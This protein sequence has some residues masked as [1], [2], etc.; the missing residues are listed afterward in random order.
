MLGFGGAWV[1]RNVM[2]VELANIG[3]SAPSRVRYAL[4]R[5]H[6]VGPTDASAT[7]LVIA[8]ASDAPDHPHGLE[9]LHGVHCRG[10]GLRR[11]LLNGDGRAAARNLSARFGGSRTCLRMRI[12]MPPLPTR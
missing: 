7:S 10:P 2:V 11:P 1:G 3:N 8:R 9:A 6:R 12:Q 5:L 4:L